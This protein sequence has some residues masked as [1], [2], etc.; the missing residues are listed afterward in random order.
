MFPY[1]ILTALPEGYPRI[2]ET[3][4]KTTMVVEM[5]FP[6]SLRCSIV[7]DPAAAVIWYKNKIPVDVLGS[8]RVQIYSDTGRPGC[9]Y[10]V[11]Q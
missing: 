3:P 4:D 9:K 10:N 5:G 1:P 6:M 8:N 11:P 7:G 2:T